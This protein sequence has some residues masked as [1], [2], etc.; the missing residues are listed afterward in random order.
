MKRAFELFDA[1]GKGS[2]SVDDLSRVVTKYTGM[3]VSK[4]EAQEYLDQQSNPVL[5]LS[6]FTDLFAKLRSVQFPKGHVIFN[7]GDA[8]MYEI[9]AG[10]EKIL[11]S[12]LMFLCSYYPLI[13]HRKAIACTLLI[14]ELFILRRS[15]F[16]V[17]LVTLIYT[18]SFV[19][20][21]L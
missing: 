11:S 2:V 14:G 1:E 8:G 12:I 3:E 10:Q 4:D 16:Y 15:C 21:N 13:L 7:A 20:I 9:T 6:E 18:S 17:E 5:G 19:T